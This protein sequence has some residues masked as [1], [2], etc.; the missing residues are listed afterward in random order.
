MFHRQVDADEFPETGGW[1]NPTPESHAKAA[2]SSH[3]MK[4]FAAKARDFLRNE[5]GVKALLATEN[6]GP[7]LSPV[8]E[9]RAHAGD[10]I[11]FHFYVDHP[12][13]P[14]SR[15]GLVSKLDNSNPLSRYR[16]P[17]RSI[18]FKRVWGSP[19][20][21][22][23][24]NFCGPNEYRSMAGLLTGAFSAIQDWTGIW[25]FT[26]AHS[27]EKL[28]HDGYA[29]SGRFDLAL[30]P[31]MQ[32]SDRLALLLFLRGDQKTPSA[33]YAN[34]FDTEAM[35]VTD[36]KPLSA[37]PGWRES[38]L[39]WRA[40]LGISFD[41]KCPDGVTCVKAYPET[42]VPPGNPP[43][44]GV[45]ADSETGRFTVCGER[46][47][48]G[49]AFPGD[50]IEAGPLVAIVKGT[51]ATVAASTLDTNP[52]RSSRRILVWHLTDLQ[53]EG[54]VFKDETR[55]GIVKWGTE[56]LIVR[57]GEAEIALALEDPVD[58]KVFA[59]E[60]DGRRS[61]GIPAV[62]KDGK[63]CFTASVRQADGAC[64]N[65]EVV[66]CAGAED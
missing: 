3:L 13:G 32:A 24:S 15:L 41:G 59:L 11:D 25:T 10:Y 20:C 54:I 58:C 53:G 65:Y 14:D 21:V 17:Y 48:G 45:S 26:Y 27:R 66:R 29:P 50:R 44:V 31:V 23:E 55:R 33:A 18:G 49:F 5:I 7:V 12:T 39:E 35:S 60:S 64:M 8:M 36:P 19:L 34:V 40:R 46:T 6:N 37:S 16:K 51:Q 9:M 42:E 22:S 30:D 62:V 52:I 61:S 2:F 57:D 38:G 47:A 63:L 43:S 56:K 1:W 28:L 4:R